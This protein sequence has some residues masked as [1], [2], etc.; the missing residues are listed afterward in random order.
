MAVPLALPWPSAMT[1]TSPAD[2]WP[3]SQLAKLT[4]SVPPPPVR[5]SLPKPPSIVLPR[6]LP[7]ITLASVFPVAFL[8]AYPPESNVR[9]STFA[10]R[11]KLT[12]E[13][14]VSMPSFADSNTESLVLPT[15]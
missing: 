14:T 7:V 15:K 12:C 1:M 5:L 4:V 8:A 10:E 9:F 2:C 13:F 3:T 6:S 11:V